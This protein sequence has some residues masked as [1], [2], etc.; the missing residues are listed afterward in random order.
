MS[1]RDFR[2]C[3][4]LNSR[5]R[6]CRQQAAPRSALSV[7]PVLANDRSIVTPDILLACHRT[8]IVRKYDGRQRRGPGWPAIAAAI[9][10]SVVRKGTE[11][12]SWVYTRIQ[13][14]LANLGDYVSRATIASILK[15]HGIEPAPERQT[16]GASRRCRQSCAGVTRTAANRAA[17]GASVPLRRAPAA[18]GGSESSRRD[19]SRSRPSWRWAGWAVGVGD[20]SRRVASGAPARACRGTPSASWRPP[21][22]TAGAG[23]AT[24]GARWH[25]R[26]TRHRPPR[27]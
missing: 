11:N 25:S 10:Q 27:R 20:P 3:L 14:A 12:R 19:R 5:R 15:Q 2:M 16:P 9:R 21:A 6:R 8:L 13:G 18:T 4:V 26:R 23:D 22:H 24:R 7:K 1:K 17:Q